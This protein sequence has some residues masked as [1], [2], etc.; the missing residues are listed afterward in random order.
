M[1]SITE[2]TKQWAAKEFGINPD[3]ILWYSSGSAYDRIGVTTKAAAD[4][5]TD[6]VSERKA[7]GGLM[8]GMPLGFQEHVAAEPGVPEYWDVTC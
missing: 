5:V 4:K 3:E 7:N 2:E 6:A 8:G 1:I